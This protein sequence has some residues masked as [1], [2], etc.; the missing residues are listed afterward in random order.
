MIKAISQKVV[1]FLR[2]C[3]FPGRVGNLLPTRSGLK[4]ERVDKINSLVLKKK[5]VGNQL[6]TLRLN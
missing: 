3:T 1:L 6:P 5:R 2:G 4:K